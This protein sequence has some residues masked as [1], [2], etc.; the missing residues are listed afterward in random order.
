[1]HSHRLWYGLVLLLALSPALVRLFLW[2]QAGRVDPVMAAA[3]KELFEHEWQVN[4][5][6]CAGGDGLGPL[7]N[8]TS[9]V[10]CHLQGGVGGS[11][12]K[13]QNVTAFTARG[14]D[15]KSHEGVI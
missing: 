12:G 14:R 8:A 5:P 13:E 7:Y 2:W 6:L 9:C 11:G 1:K 4:D 3:G 15:Q 10:A